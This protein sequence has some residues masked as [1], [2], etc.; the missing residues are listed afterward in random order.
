MYSSLADITALAEF[1]HRNQ[2][3]KA[4]MPYFQHPRRVL[5]SVQ[6]QGALPYVQMAAILHD[7]IEDTPFTAQ[8]LLDLGVP[9]AAVEVVILLT[10]V[11]GV[12]NEDYYKK[13]RV[14][15]AAR[16]VKLS[17]IDDNTQEWRLAYLPETTRARLRV[18][19]A[20]ARAWLNFEEWSIPHMEKKWINELGKQ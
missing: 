16:M 11:K 18:K 4:G 9:E 7:V 13:I 19:Y 20:I 8:M 6:N 15:E 3:D 1:A 2:Q 10:K 17:D 12:S 14:N 5:R